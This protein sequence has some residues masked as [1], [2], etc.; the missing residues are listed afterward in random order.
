[1]WGPARNGFM[2][3]PQCCVVSSV[4]KRKL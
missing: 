4:S 3:F 2:K 1:M